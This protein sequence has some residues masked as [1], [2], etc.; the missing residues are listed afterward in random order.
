MSVN[1][2]IALR[3][4]WNNKL[5]TFINVIGLS[6]GLASCLIILIHVK[7]ELGF[8]RFHANNDR[9]IRVIND[10][11][12]D[13][14]TPMIMS[15]VL[16]EYFPGVEKTVRI[17]KSDWSRF[18]MIKDKNAVEETD[19]VYTDSTFFSIFTFPLMSGDDRQVLRSPDRIMLSERMAQKYFGSADPT[20]MPISLRLS[21]ITYPFIIEGVFRNFPEQSHF[22]ANF[23]AS[24]E[25]LKKIRGERA[26]TSWGL[27]TVHT[28]MLLEK[29]GMQVEM[30]KRLPGFIDKYVPKDIA[31]DLKYSFQP[32]TRI[33]LYSKNIPLDIEPQG[34]ISR[35]VIFASVAL[36]VLIIAIVNFV[37]LSLALSHKRIKE[38]GIRKI[39]GARQKELVSLVST[40]FIIVFLLALQIA[41]M[42]AELTIPWL[43][44]NMDM[45]V[46]QGVFAHVGILLAF[47]GI[48]G[49]LG[50]LASIYITGS[51]SRIRPIDTIKGILP[52][53]RARIPTRGVLV[54]FQFSIMIGLLSC[55]MIMQKQLILVRNTDLGYRKDQLLSV[56]IP[57]NSFDKYLLLKE[58]LKSIPGVE[59]V[60]GAAYMPPSGQYWI[61]KL[62]NPQTTEEFQFEEINGDFDLIETL[63]IDL[64]LGRTFSRDFGTDTT[65]ILINESGLRLLGTDDPLGTTLIR[66]END[67]AR[68]SFTIIGVFRDFHARSLYDK[69]QPMAVLLSPQM[70]RQLAIRI[71]SA[72][73]G[74]TLKEIEKR[75][76]GIY[77]ED[78]I[79]Y[80]FVDEALHLKYKKEDQSF[81]LISL[82]AF[83]SFMIAFMGLFGLSAFAAERRTKEIGVRK[84][85]G[86]TA[87]DIL[88]LFC[89]QF[90]RWI[91]IAFLIALPLAWF[92]MDRWLQ[93]FAY[94]TPISWWVF[95]LSLLVSLLVAAI[96][97]S[98]QTYRAATRN[99]VEALRYE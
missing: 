59:G 27:S 31:A 38:F 50:F 71:T 10:N 62:K 60:S 2:K 28:Y 82:F 41:F 26:Q 66:L 79:Q 67:P 15:S 35:V 7:F 96:T 13:S 14:Y 12:G 68:A 30:E 48:T 16:P 53:T 5:F 85:N 93:H 6:L 33:H 11:F 4:L 23:L 37:L 32:L 34:N 8:D 51:V 72:N 21:N 76:K 99:P 75:W 20:G 90:G 83:L 52:M 89:R 97:I 3:H 22:H 70:V 55:L 49:L 78:P 56:D 74:I 64:V 63:D 40:E 81:F 88:Y 95:A 94:R 19:L 65:A 77:P 9:I 24:M 80:T 46:R 25:F 17:G 87:A 1:L 47:A 92:G 61:C 91:T 54:I 86:A 18:Y 98:W 43:A 39:V 84:V 36:L 69:V 42:L 29:P 73:T 58:E 57:G 44:T 45:N